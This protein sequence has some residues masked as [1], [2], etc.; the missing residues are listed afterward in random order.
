MSRFAVV[1][2]NKH[3]GVD[4]LE[5]YDE[6]DIH[7]TVADDVEVQGVYGPKGEDEL[8]MDWMRETI[9]SLQPGQGV[10]LEHSGGGVYYV[11]RFP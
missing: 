5:F 3:R 7:D 2:T 11:Q 8:D 10:S 6:M 9:N 1:I 4:S